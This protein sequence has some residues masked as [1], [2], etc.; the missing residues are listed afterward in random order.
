MIDNRLKHIGIIMDGNGRWAQARGKKRTAGHRA[1]GNTL[2]K[3]ALHAC[4][5]GLE[6][7]SV[8][9]FS[10]DNFK[11]DAEEVNSLMDLVIEYFNTKFTKIMKK[12]IKV[13]ISGTKQGLRDDVIKAI[14]SIEEQSKNNTKATLNI[15]LNYGGQEE[16]IRMAERYHDDLVNNKVKKGSLNRE[17]FAKY[18][19]NYLPP[20][21]IL[22]RTGGEKRLSNFMLYNL[23]YAEIFFLDVYFPDFNNEM[24][25]EV[26]EQFYQKDRRFGGINE[27]KGN[28]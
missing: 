10:V 8:F 1:G 3:L 25:D 9:A 4:D 12:G 20:M 7:L 13:V 11:R 15:C 24:L 17:E 19:D 5:I 16:I 21:D 23:S 2:E 26:I 6:Y 14:E 22:I 28:S 27:K 18:M